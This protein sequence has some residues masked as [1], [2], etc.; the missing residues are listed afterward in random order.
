MNNG[1]NI[2]RVIELLH[3]LRRGRHVH[4]ERLCDGICT[5]SMLEKVELGKRRLNP[6]YLNRLLARLGIDQKKYEKCLYHAEYDNW[7]RKNDI[8]NLVEDGELQQAEKMLSMLEC[9][10]SKKDRIDLQFCKFIRA[11]ILQQQGASDDELFSL[12]HDALL[13]TVPNAYE[14]ET[15]RLLL[16]ADE[17]N[18]MLECRCREVRDSDIYEA[19]EIFEGLINYIDK[20]GYDENCKPKI[21][22]KTVVYMFNYIESYKGCTD[23][24]YRNIIYKKMIKYCEVAVEMLLENKRLYYLCELFE[25]QEKLL[26]Y[27]NN[28]DKHK[29]EYLQN[30]DIYKTKLIEARTLLEAYKAVCHKYDISPYMQDCCY[31]YREEDVHCINEVMKRRREMLGITMSAL[32]DNI[33]STRTISRLETRECNTHGGIVDELLPRLGICK[34]F[35]NTGIY[36]RDKENLDLY[37]RCKRAVNRSDIV[38]SKNLYH[39]L[40]G[41]LE[42]NELNRQVLLQLKSLVLWKNNEITDTVYIK[43]IEDSMKYTLN[44]IKLKNMQGLKYLSYSEIKCVHDIGVVLYMKGE[45]IAAMRKM[46]IL[47]EYFQVME[48]E[49]LLDTFIDSYEMVM[50]SH[51]RMAVSAEKYEYSKEIFFKLNRLSLKLKRINLADWREYNV[52]WKKFM[53]IENGKISSNY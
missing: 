3:D 16:S 5:K 48:E 14:V 20:S 7:K 22:P 12:Y 25:I 28:T 23:N 17:Y 26:T 47:I 24:S 9:K 31:L 15:D 43:N 11:Q 42:D 1:G 46:D 38:L 39:E 36:T 33:C 13:L 27:I 6:L 50:I 21:Y 53:K 45:F 29:C 19:L 37:E 2:K 34:E 49:G 4:I 52:F 51:A 35:T 40:E 8:I 10:C 44:N 32:S 30:M 18:L 41:K